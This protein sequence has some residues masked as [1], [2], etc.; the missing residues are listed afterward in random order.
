MAL[1]QSNQSLPNEGRRKGVVLSQILK[2][3]PILCWD[4]DSWRQ[5]SGNYLTIR[6]GMKRAATRKNSATA[7]PGLARSDIPSWY[8]KYNHP[9]VGSSAPQR[10]APACS[11][12]DHVHRDQSLK[13]GSFDQAPTGLENISTSIKGAQPFHKTQT[14]LWMCTYFDWIHDSDSPCCSDFGL[15]ALVLL[16]VYLFLMNHLLLSGPAHPNILGLFL[17]PCRHWYVSTGFFV[18]KKED[19]F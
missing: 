10:K 2:T 5:S 7:A 6:D 8:H 4:R 19:H 16:L 18:S 13:T 9:F 17:A 12:F 15:R 11:P 3:I 14:K 1:L